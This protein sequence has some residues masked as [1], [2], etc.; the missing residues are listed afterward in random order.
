MFLQ[1]SLSTGTSKDEGFET[2][3][4]GAL[5]CVSLIQLVLLNM[6]RVVPPILQAFIESVRTFGDTLTYKELLWSIRY[7]RSSPYKLKIKALLLAT[8]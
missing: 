1:V 8:T 4:G 3:R 7:V 6:T 2:D 5:R